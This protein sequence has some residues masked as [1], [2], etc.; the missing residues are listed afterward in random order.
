ML[1]LSMDVLHLLSVVVEVV[2]L[3]GIAAAAFRVI[4]AY[5]REREEAFRQLQAL[6]QMKD[7]LTHMIVH[8]MKNPIQGLVASVPLLQEADEEL[9]IECLDAIQDA[10]HSLQRMVANLL[11]IAQLEEGVLHIEPRPVDV[12]EVL[13]AV[14][15]QLGPA[16]RLYYTS[17]ELAVEGATPPASGDAAML[18]RVIA[19]LLINA[20]KHTRTPEPVTIVAHGRDH[21]VEIRVSD[22]GP[23]IPLEQQARIFD[24][25]HRG[26]AGS[27]YSSG[28]S[29]LGLAFCRL[30]M[31]AH[32]GAIGVDS[33][34]DA[35]AS[36]WIWLPAVQG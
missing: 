11:G 16:A 33:A 26:A 25:F 28:S 4:A 30:A 9:R 10:A 35:G 24:K 31:E 3:A 29:G 2:I 19:N 12:G 36:F 5:E 23:G 13:E 14:A 1:R 21:G 17:V 27:A 7:D 20:I 32:G 34:P 22:H 6:G 8:D 15:R 18:E